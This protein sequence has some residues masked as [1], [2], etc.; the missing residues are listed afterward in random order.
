L[1]GEFAAGSGVVVVGTHQRSGG[2]E[3][4]L[5]RRHQCGADE[6]VRVAPFRTRPLSS[7]PAPSRERSATTTP[8]SSSP[9]RSPM[10]RASR[11]AS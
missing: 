3:G 8:A 10:P 5:D 2:L 1:G 6:I 11:Y 9:R 4:F 7:R